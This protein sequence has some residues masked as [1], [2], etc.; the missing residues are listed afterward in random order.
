MAANL[1]LVGVVIAGGRSLRFGGE[2]AVAPYRGRPLLLWAVQRLQRSCD[3]VVVN[4]RAGT[5]AEA[6]ALREGLVVLHDLPGDPDGPLSGV[7]VSLRW[8]AERGAVAVAASPCDA[9]CLPDDLFT[10]LV[11]AAGDGAAY[12]ETVEGR[13]PLCAVWPV[14]A[15]PSLEAALAGERHPPTWRMLEAVGAVTLRV[16]PP[17]GFINVNT[18]DDLDRLEATAHQR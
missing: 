1:H 15:L 7:K 14:T 2:K 10:R 8:A 18:R 11:A 9:P 17:E 16:D 3:V 4:A 13:Q 12:A 6:L 5:E